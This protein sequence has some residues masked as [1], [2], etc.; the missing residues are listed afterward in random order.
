VG[1]SV[2]RLGDSV[3][4]ALGRSDP[5]GVGAGLGRAVGELLGLVDGDPIVHGQSST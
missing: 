3:G 5:K 1:F 4:I 2:K